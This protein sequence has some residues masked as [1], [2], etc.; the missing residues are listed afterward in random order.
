ML[1][2]EYIL[3]RKSTDLA[4]ACISAKSVDSYQTV[5][6]DIHSN[7]LFSDCGL[8]LSKTSPGFYVSAV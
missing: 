3:A 4:Y 8:I 7:I 6:V 5:Q 2:I 1:K